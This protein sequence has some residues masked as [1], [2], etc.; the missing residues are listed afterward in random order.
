M[1][2]SPFLE[3][4]AR[5]ATTCVSP[6]AARPLSA[7]DRADDCAAIADL[8]FA[9]NCGNF[10]PCPLLFPSGAF[11]S[12]LNAE[13][14]RDHWLIMKTQIR[15]SAGVQSAAAPCSRIFRKLTLVFGAARLAANSFAALPVVETPIYRFTNSAVTGGSPK[16]RLIFGSDGALYGTTPYGATGRGANYHSANYYSANCRAAYGS[17]AGSGD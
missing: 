7:K 3:A 16:S 17:H 6:R 11:Y 10:L 5:E 2:F 1:G 9:V 14:L 12:F 8:L 4:K 13:S 15:T